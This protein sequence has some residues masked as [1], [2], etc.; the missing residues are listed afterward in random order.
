MVLTVNIHDQNGTLSS[1][2]SLAREMAENMKEVPQR[3]RGEMK[4]VRD[5]RVFMLSMRQNK[6]SFMVNSLGKQGVGNGK[7]GRTGGFLWRKR[8]SDN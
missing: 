3:I 4:S 6:L 8:N 1:C 2:A 7:R 5:R